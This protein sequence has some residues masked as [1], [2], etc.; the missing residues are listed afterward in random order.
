MTRIIEAINSNKNV[1]RLKIGILTDEGLKALSELIK[2]NEHLEELAIQET[3]N[4]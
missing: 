3:S 1:K 4:H 2:P